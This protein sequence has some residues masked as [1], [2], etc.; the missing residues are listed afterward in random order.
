M[1]IICKDT[2]VI[3][4]KVDRVAMICKHH[5]MV[6]RKTLFLLPSMVI[7]LVTMKKMGK[8]KEK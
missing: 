1:H 2:F 7:L 3:S 5:Y 6:K 4:S 8:Q